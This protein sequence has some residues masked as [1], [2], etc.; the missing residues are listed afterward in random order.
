MVDVMFEG[1]F[2][3]FISHWAVTANCAGT[4][5]TS[6]VLRE[7]HRRWKVAATTAIHPFQRSIGIHR[8]WFHRN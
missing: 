2:Q 6:S 4:L 7:E 5:D 1:V 8:G 3:T